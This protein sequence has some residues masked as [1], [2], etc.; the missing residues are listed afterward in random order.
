MSL[1]IIIVFKSLNNY[2]I[3]YVYLKTD[4]LLFIEV[5]C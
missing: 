4:Y 3:E 5:K 1:L 2:L